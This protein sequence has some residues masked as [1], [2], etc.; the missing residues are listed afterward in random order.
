[1][2]VDLAGSS[3]TSG[4]TLSIL[5][6]NGGTPCNN[7]WIGPGRLTVKGAN[8]TGPVFQLGANDV[9]DNFTMSQ[10][11][12]LICQQYDATQSTTAAGCKIN[13]VDSSHLRLLAYM[14]NG[15]DGTSSS[16]AAGVELVQLVQ[17][18]LEI[19]SNIGGGTGNGTPLKITGASIGNNVLAFSGNAAGA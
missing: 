11:D 1:G 4:P 10:I 15:S 2:G 7:L 17:S 19:Q 14:V 5:C 8:A 18:D 16:A 9:S 6:T 3:I 13:K 12:Y